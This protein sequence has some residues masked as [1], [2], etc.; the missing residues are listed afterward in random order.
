MKIFWINSGLLPDA[1]HAIG[2]KEQVTAGWVNSLL[3]AL[4]TV[5]DGRDEYF[6]LSF[7]HRPCDVQVGRV[8]YRSFG[9]KGCCTYGA[10]IPS[11]VIDAVRTSVAEFDPDIIHVHGTEYFYGRLPADVYGGK[12][13]VVS[14]Q[15]ILTGLVPWLTGNLSQSEVFWHQFNLRRIRYNATIFNDQKDWYRSRLPQEAKIF[16]QHQYF[17]GRTDWDRKWLAALNPKARYFS[18]NETLRPPFYVANRRRPEMIRRHSIY[19]SAAA[20]YPLKGAHV[21]FRAVAMLKGKYPDIQVHVCAAEKLNSSRSLMMIL[22]DDQYGSYLR[23]LIRELGIRENVVGLPFLSAEGVADELA[24][25]E[26]FV[27]PSYCE[28]SPNSLGEAQ[29]IGT[30]AIATYAGGIPSVL[31][32]GIDGI[33]VQPGDV[34]ALAAEIDGFFQHVD[35]AFTYAASAYESAIVRH[36]PKMNATRTFAVYDEILKQHADAS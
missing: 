3:Q 2:H 12:P 9:E 7:D 5:S 15:G 27:L 19:C 32:N 26:L 17:M 31:K 24:R 6:V 8:H 23:S 25:A 4:L 18:V 28:N 29:L 36:D 20:G 30:P 22:K 14:I 33:L 10:H 1:C 16:R 35:K 13:V 11:S 21:L 34:A